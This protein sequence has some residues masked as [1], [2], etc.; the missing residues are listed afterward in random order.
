MKKAKA[1]INKPVYLGMQIL[2]VSKLLMYDFWFDYIKLK[3]QDKRKLCYMDA[4]SSVILIAAYFYKDI[5]N[6]VKKWFDT[7]NYSDCKWSLP[8]GKNKKIIGV[9]KDELGEKILR[10]FV[11]LRAKTYGY[12][13][14]NDNEQKS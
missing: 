13:M 6:D 7:S 8:I 14:D 3:Y 12:L 4:D 10:K 5:S 2:D 1:K 11:G 9:F